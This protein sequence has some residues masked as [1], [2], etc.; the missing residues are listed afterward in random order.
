MPASQHSERGRLGSVL[1]ARQPTGL[2]SSIA[3]D[4]TVHTSGPN[5]CS[6]SG[7]DISFLATRMKHVAAVRKSQQALRHPLHRFCTQKFPVVIDADLLPLYTQQTQGCPAGEQPKYATSISA[8]SNLRYRAPN[9][10]VEGSGRGSSGR[11]GSALF[12]WR[13]VPRVI[14]PDELRLWDDIRCVLL[15]LLINGSFYWVPV[16]LVWVWRRHCTTRR[17]KV[18]FALVVLSILLFPIR[19]RAGFRKWNGWRNLHRY[20][21]TSVIVER[22]EMF[23]PREPTI[24]AVFP[25]GIIPTAPA[26]MATADFGNLLGYFRLT[27][28]SVLRWCL[29]YGQLIFL[30]DAIPADRAPMKENLEQ[31]T[32]LLVSPGGIAEM[33]ETSPEQERLHLHD[34]QGIVRL[35]MET[36]ARLVPIYCFGHSQAYRLPWG[37]RFLQPLARLLR[38]SLITFYGRFALPV[39]FRVPFLFAIGR[40]LQLPQTDKPS[41]AEVASAHRLLVGEVQRI[42]ETYK[43]LYGWSERQLEIL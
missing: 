6:S 39:A 3:T 27:A 21:R 26:A 42:F 28:A 17:R 1:T 41:R 7:L 29:V 9:A 40:P 8:F 18:V 25:H 10:P 33:Y 19:A 5:G 4:T 43:G 24:Y 11:S 22:S 30:T 36:G 38:A 32:S 12:P 31:G 23:P 34:R 13:D 16:L 20:H 15:Q 35:A 2:F 14:P 37:V